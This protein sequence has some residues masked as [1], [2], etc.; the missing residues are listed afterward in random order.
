MLLA[1][2]E[3]SNMNNNFTLAHVLN[4]DHVITEAVSGLLEMDMCLRH[5]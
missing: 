4:L 3:Q 5:G 2:L 1:N